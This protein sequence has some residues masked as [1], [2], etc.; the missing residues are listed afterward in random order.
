MAAQKPQAGINPSKDHIISTVDPPT[1]LAGI[2][3]TSDVYENTRHLKYGQSNEEKKEKQE[4]NL[5]DSRPIRRYSASGDS[6]PVLQHTFYEEFMADKTGD[7]LIEQEESR[8]R[9]RK[10]VVEDEKGEK[11]NKHVC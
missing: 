5:L 4:Q 8:E 2:P 9:E 10:S 1:G 11:K 6:A 7:D 3:T